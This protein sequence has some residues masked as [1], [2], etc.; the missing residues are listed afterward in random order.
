D[1]FKTVLIIGCFLLAAGLWN[2][3][4]FG[5]RNVDVFWGQAALG[6]GLIMIASALVI[7]L[8]LRRPAET[9]KHRWFHWFLIAGLFM[10]FLLYAITIVQLNLGMEILG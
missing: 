9:L 1:H 10:H 8:S 3:F 2:T 4:W 7:L 5:L 6:S